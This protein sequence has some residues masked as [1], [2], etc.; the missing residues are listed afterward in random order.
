VKGFVVGD[1]GIELAHYGVDLWRWAMSI[2]LSFI[3]LLKNVIRLE[4]SYLVD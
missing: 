2:Y 4:K 1:H 3:V